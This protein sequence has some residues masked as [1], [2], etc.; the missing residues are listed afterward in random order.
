MQCSIVLANFRF[1]I[2]LT[3]S[4]V[5]AVVTLLVCRQKPTAVVVKGKLS[6]SLNFIMRFL[7]ANE[8]YAGIR[9]ADLWV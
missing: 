7:S 8:K 4:D 9:Y 2:S 6:V 3:N 5:E 1:A